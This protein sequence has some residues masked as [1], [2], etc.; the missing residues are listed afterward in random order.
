MASESESR[1]QQYRFGP[2]YLDARSGELRKHGTKLK[3][4]GHPIQILIHLLEHPGELVT[5]EQLRERLW[6]ADTFVDFEHGL[7]S[8]I[9]RLRQ[10]LLDKA[11]QPR[12]IET[13]PRRGYRF[14]GAVE[15]AGGLD[16]PASNLAAPRANFAF[17]PPAASE[18]TPALELVPARAGDESRAEAPTRGESGHGK[19]TL[20]THRR[21]VLAGMAVVTLFAIFSL[22]IKSRTRNAAPPKINSIAVLPLKNLSGDPGQEYLADGMTETLI[23]RLSTIHDLRVISRTSVMRFKNTQLSAPEIARTLGADS[24]VEGSVI[25]EGG[26]IRVHAQLIRAATDEQF[27]SESYDREPQDILSLES[28]VAQA[29]ARKVEVTVTG[30]ERARLIA[31]RRVDPEAHESY[32]KGLRQLNQSNTKADKAGI[33]KSVPYFET[34]IRSDATFAPAYVG[35][36]KAYMSLSLVVVGG[37]P[38][39]LRPKAIS[40]ARKALELDPELADAHSLLAGIYLAQWQWSDSQGEFERALVLN[41]NDAS[42]HFGYAHWLLCQGRTDEAIAWSQRARKLDPLGFAGFNSGW[43]LFQSRHYDEAIRELRSAIAVNPDDAWSH[44]LLGFVLIVNDHAVEA[45]PILDKTVSMMQRSPGS[46]G[47]LASAYAHVGRRDDALRLIDELKQRREKGYVPAAAFVIPY[48][49]LGENDQVFKWL[50]RAYKEQS[51][52]LQFLKVYPGFDS[53]RGD[54]R[55]SDLLR[56][57]GLE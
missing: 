2:F 44:W 15:C 55:F 27:W 33:E 31:V 16:H 13:V 45:I 34:A 1:A 24:I 10:T 35:L 56:R 23:G 4:R 9:K 50:E 32:L 46:I 12:Y 30:E 54:P 8:A 51:T 18:S 6:P 19:R 26:R 20:W 21:L 29:I 25:R 57:V 47:L 52:M 40:A 38:G 22:T 39:E 3:L 17:P 5:R 37:D 14:I 7:N 28:E 41:P 53:V 49:A 42:A 48:L 11:D 36:A 43:I